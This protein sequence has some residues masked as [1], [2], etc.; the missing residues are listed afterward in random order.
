MSAFLRNPEVEAAGRAGVLEEISHGGDELVRNFLRLVSEKGRAGEIV[1]MS[2][3]L[4]S[5]VARAQN[6]L[7]VE[8]Q[9]AQELS[10]R[11]L[12]RS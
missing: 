7:A 10:T 3:E 6:R 8:L 4:E 12:R 5:L 1:G 9:T 11:R 2:A